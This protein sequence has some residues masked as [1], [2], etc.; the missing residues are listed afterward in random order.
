VIYVC[1]TPFAGRRAKP[2]RHGPWNGD[3]VCT[4]QLNAPSYMEA[5]AGELKVNSAFGGSADARADTEITA[6][7]TTFTIMVA[8]SWC[9][10]LFT[11][12]PCMSLL[13]NC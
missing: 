11:Q 13:F 9:I 12:Y 3:R 10:H 4:H 7:V 6:K 2:C 8:G 1:V 5:T